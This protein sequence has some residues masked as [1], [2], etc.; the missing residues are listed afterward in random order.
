M[1]GKKLT[2]TQKSCLSKAG[3]LMY[4]TGMLH[5]G[6]RIG[7]AV[8]GGM[9]SWV[10]LQVLLLQQKKLPF[11][12]EVCVLHI[13]PGFDPHNH[14]PLVDWL[15]RNGVAGHVV[16]TDMGLRAHSSENRKNSPCFFCSWHRRKRLFQLVKQYHLSHLAM[17]HTADDMVQNFFMNLTHN[18]RVE[19]M[20]PR[21]SYFQG[22][23]QL[24]RPLLL[25]EK[26]LI[27]KSVR[28]WN[29]PVWD[30]PCPSNGASNRD[31]VQDWLEGLWKDNKRI[32][33]NIFSGLQRWQLYA[34]IQE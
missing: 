13:N 5:P 27:Q 23:F 30:N 32:R 14:A 4:E 25:V 1:Q 11:S 6:A 33:K 18:G 21:E 12:V 9:D 20:F 15:S 3:K 2:Y 22:E 28:E 7:V 24:I 29:L 19:A 26:R 16:V 31:Q 34:N 10:L 8:S 17:G